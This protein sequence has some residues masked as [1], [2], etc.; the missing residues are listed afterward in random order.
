MFP[1]IA[2]VL[3]HSIQHS[4]S[5]KIFQHWFDKYQI[6]GQYIIADMSDLDGFR[7][8]VVGTD[9]KFFNV[10]TPFKE[11]ILTYLDKIDEDVAAIGACNCVSIQ[12]GKWLGKN[13]DHYGVEQSLKESKDLKGKKFLLIGY[14]G[15]AKAVEFALKKN[16][17]EFFIVSRR[18]AGG[19]IS[20]DDVVDLR[21]IDVVINANGCNAP[22]EL[23]SHIFSKNVLFFD[24]D[25]GR[26]SPFAQV[27]QDGHFRF[28]DGKRMLVHQAV[29][30]FKNNFGFDPEC[31]DLVL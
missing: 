8:T 17:A 11:K 26:R 6:N 10:T 29:K 31:K 13:T 23:P 7:Q 14:G 4:L 30:V 27:A 9:L 3:G 28:T 21:S 2:C 20:W 18:P 12:G 22:G 16:D 5:P 1:T 24:L 25:Y 19:V 15:A